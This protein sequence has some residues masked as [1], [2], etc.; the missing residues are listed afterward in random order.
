MCELE[1]GE[2]LRVE[3][4]HVLGRHCGP[5]REDL[6]MYTNSK[7]ASSCALRSCTF[8]AATLDR[9]SKTTGMCELEVGELLRVEVRH[10][11]GR[12]R[13]PKIEDSRQA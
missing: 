5:N 7:L 9:K 6:G 10:V 13:G 4:L 8:P 1:A 3:I 12:H 11:L 2:L